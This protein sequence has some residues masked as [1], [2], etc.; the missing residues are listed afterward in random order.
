MP[1]KAFKRPWPLAFTFKKKFNFSSKQYKTHNLANGILGEE[2]HKYK[3]YESIDQW[4]HQT[5]TI[6]K[7]LT[8]IVDGMKLLQ[9][10]N[11]IK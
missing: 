7:H 6:T 8:T 11:N 2:K 10:E 4:W 9:Y 5:C 1:I 3:F